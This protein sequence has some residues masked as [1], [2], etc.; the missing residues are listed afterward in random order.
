MWVLEIKQERVHEGAK[1]WTST[2]TLVF[3]FSELEDATGMASTVL[4]AEPGFNTWV[5]IKKEEEDGT[6]KL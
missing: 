3:K 1:P 2:E 6:E 5:K 4:N